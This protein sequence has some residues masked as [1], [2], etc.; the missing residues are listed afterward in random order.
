MNLDT[1]TTAR[2]T[3][4]LEEGPQRKRLPDRRPQ[5]TEP[6]VVGDS[7]YTASVG[8]DPELGIVRELF[9]EGAKPGSDMAHL[10]NDIAVVMS[11]VMQHGLP[12]S[13]FVGAVARVPETIDGPPTKPATA[14]GAA[15]DLVARYEREGAR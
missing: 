6:L 8:F 9:L 13:L 5:L 12:A 14:L 2:L 10:L 3:H 11:V 4:M 1:I 15:I 7:T